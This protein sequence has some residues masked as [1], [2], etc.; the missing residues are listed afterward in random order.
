MPLEQELDVR[1]RDVLAAGGDDQLLLAV[2]DPEEAVGVK[3]ADIARVHPPLGVDRGGRGLEVAVV[4]L[5]QQRAAHWTSPSA[6]SRSSTPGQG[7]PTLPLRARSGWLS[8][9]TVTSVMPTSRPWGARG[10]GR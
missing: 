3:R 10:P 9:A 4:A 6:A 1:R 2:Y 7:V 5:H 8:V